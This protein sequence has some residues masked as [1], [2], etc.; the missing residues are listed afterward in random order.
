MRDLLGKRIASLVVACVGECEGMCM[1]IIINPLHGVSRVSTRAGFGSWGRWVEWGSLGGLAQVFGCGKGGGLDLMAR[2][3][4][5][6]F[7]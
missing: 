4:F 5:D 1:D 3:H 6:E 2:R 7:S